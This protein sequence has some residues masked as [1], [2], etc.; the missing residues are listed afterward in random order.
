MRWASDLFSTALPD[1]AISPT[2]Q[3]VGRPITFSRINSAQSWTTLRKIKFPYVAIMYEVRVAKCS[4]CSG[5]DSQFTHNH[6][7]YLHLLVVKLDPAPRGHK[8]KLKRVYF[9][10]SFLL[11]F[12]GLGIATCS[13][14]NGN[15]CEA[16]RQTDQAELWAVEPAEMNSERSLIFA[17]SSLATHFTAYSALR[18]VCAQK[19]GLL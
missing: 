4:L 16:Q 6:F 7:Y 11:P 12:A 1:A 18:E 10:Y 19:G 13:N 5:N 17:R 15:S 3:S 9:N 14:W 8:W 2:S